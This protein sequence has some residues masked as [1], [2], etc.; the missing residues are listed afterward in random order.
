MVLSAGHH[1]NLPPTVNVRSRHQF[2]CYTIEGL[3]SFSTVFY[4]TYIYF[5]LREK[6]GF[7]D[8]ANLAVA[9]LLG[10]IYAFVAWQTGKFAQRYGNLN[11][12][13]LGFSVMAVSYLLG[14]QWATAPGQIISAICVSIG[15]CFTWPVLE[16]LVSEGAAPE[17]I[18]HAVGLYN[19]TW[20]WTNAG[21][22][23]LGGTLL[24]KGG[25]NMLFWIPLAMVLLQLCLV[26][27]L[28]RCPLP[29]ITATGAPVADPLRPSPAKAKKFQQLAWLANPFAYIAINTL[30][31][32]LPGVA[33]K[34]HLSNTLAGFALSLWGFARLATFVVLWRWHGWHYRFRWLLTAY[35][36]LMLAFAAI[37]AVPN[38]AVV[39]VA[40]VLF[41]AAI[42]LMYYS[43]LFY[44]MDASD[45]KSEHGGIH[46]AA[47]GIGNCLG[48]AAGA[49]ALWLAPNNPSMDV[50]A[51][52]SLLTIGLGGLIWVQKKS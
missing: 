44:A 40:Q 12:L 26:F 51:V 1:G 42:G 27:V 50:W 21:A 45:T 37:L 6:Y 39:L 49:A 15:M 13:K 32:V 38:L 34:F 10:V 17:R 35:V 24:E 3:N 20:A 47:I 48:P 30:L 52:S 25:P 14:S 18:P 4:F 7:G 41:G 29:H 8:A 16:A 22:V 11:A 46:E 19:I 28:Q 36:L 33:A 2:L 23:F 31:A 5:Q 9:A 43:S